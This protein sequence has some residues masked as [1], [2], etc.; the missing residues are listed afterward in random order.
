[1]ASV[2][3]RLERVLEREA[4]SWGIRPVP[5]EHRRL[6]GLDFAVLWGDLS[7]GLLVLVTGA[8]LVPALGFPKA[9]LAIVIGS[10]VGCL[11][12]ALV[13]L[14]GARE[15]VP[16]MVLFRPVLG[17]R[18][19]FL[20]SALNL[21]QLVGWTAV[22]FWAMGQIA[23]VLSERAFGRSA[24]VPWLSVVAVVCTVLALGGP[25]LVVRRWLERFGIYVVLASAAWITYQAMVAADLSTMWGRPGEGGLPFWL[26][27]DLVIV[28]PISWLPLVADYN[29]FSRSGAR[30]FAGTYWGYFLGNVWFYTLGALLV[31]AVG[32]SPD[33][34]GVG[35]A[36][37][38]LAGGSL[39]L[40]ALLIGESDNAFANIYSSAV[41]VQN[42]APAAPQRA[43]ILAVGAVGFL[44]ALFLSMDR[45]EVFLFLIGSVFVPLF[46]VFA[47]DYFVR[48]RARYGERDLFQR[49]GRFWYR[50][51]VNWAALV[52]WSLGFVLYHWSVRTGPAGWVEAV[53]TVFHDWLGLPFPLFGS[54]IGASLPSFLA[55]FALSLLVLPR[56]GAPATRQPA[57]V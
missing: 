38:A 56:T 30:E 54:A 24:Y 29:R 26:G 6:S 47:A 39:L 23:T 48:R 49:E 27:V 16:G 35:T 2:T 41:S 52:P 5:P 36:I 21:V 33:V 17:L 3:D 20:P 12:L 19:S 31:L 10:A 8:L 11:P 42:V 13:G 46:G 53:E 57:A 45:Y 55:A 18:G 9:L 15:G 34:S 7:V 40:V 28:M 1:M 37:A 22:E 51:G 43:L 50:G 32:A 4:P 44:L 25:I 14:A